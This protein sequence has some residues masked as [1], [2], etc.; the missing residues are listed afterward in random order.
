[1]PCELSSTS[2][3][4]SVETVSVKLGQP[5]PEWYFARLSKSRLP[6]AAQWKKPASSVSTYSPE[7]GRSVAASR[8]TAYCSVES[9]LRHSSSVRD[10]SSLSALTTSPTG[11]LTPVPPKPQY[12][13]GTFCRYCWW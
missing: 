4:A 3:T 9:R 7:N 8:R 5:V 13:L 10:S 12:P 1:M 11:Q 6:Q 2:S